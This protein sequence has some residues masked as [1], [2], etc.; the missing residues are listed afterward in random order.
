MLF[1]GFAEAAGGNNCDPGKEWVVELA[2][3]AV[4]AMRAVFNIMH[5]QS[6]GLMAVDVDSN[7]F[8][9][10]LYDIVV[11]ADKY[12]CIS[13]LRPYAASWVQSLKAEN[14]DEQALLRLSWIFYQLGHKSKYED[15]VTRLI[16]DVADTKTGNP[17]ADLDLPA[18]L[19][20]HLLESLHAVR[21]RMLRQLLDPISFSVTAL[22]TGERTTSTGCSRDDKLAAQCESYMLG[23]ALREL[24][25]KNLYPVPTA[26]DM[27][28]SLT[29]LDA[30]IT[31]LAAACS[32]PRFLDYHGTCR[33]F[34]PPLRTFGVEWGCRNLKRTTYA[35]EYKYTVDVS[36]LR[37]ITTQAGRTGVDIF[38]PAELLASHKAPFF[39][40]S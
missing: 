34:K 26:K 23:K 40:A 9:S 39:G 14:K 31:E 30:V 4:P 32:G 33:A 37:H 36:E 10:R 19:P 13:S 21:E 24:H 35:T 5:G 25:K 6:R 38:G 27:T 7:T 1:G 18:V 3:D 12:D 22:I 20:P 28:L 2:G 15:V 16:K 29:A 8:I 17:V 11:V